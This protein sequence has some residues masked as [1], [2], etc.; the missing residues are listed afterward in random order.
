MA[1][2]ELP[3]LTK[4]LD[5]LAERDPTVCTRDPQSQPKD[6]RFDLVCQEGY[7][8]LITSDSPHWLH[9]SMLLTVLIGLIELKNLRLRLENSSEGWYATVIKV[10][11]P[12]TEGLKTVYRAEPE[13]ATL[14]AYLNCVGD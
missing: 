11:D 9:R 10:D 2:A 14:E 1:V 3:S 4:L 5:R 8:L 13:M 12:M 7:P 6:N